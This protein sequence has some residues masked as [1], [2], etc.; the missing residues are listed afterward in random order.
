MSEDRPGTDIVLPLMA[1]V[2]LPVLLRFGFTQSADLWLLAPEL[3]IIAA[4]T[5]VLALGF[6]VGRGALALV[7][8]TGIVIAGIVSVLQLYGVSAWG[9]PAQGVAFG[10]V[11][12]DAFA[13][14]L[15]LVFLSVAGLVALASPTAV[16][17]RANQGE[18]YSL[19]LFATVGMMFVGGSR[20]LIMLFLGF[21]LSSFASYALAGYRK[22]DP[23]S[24]EAAM[25]FFING[26]LSSALILFGISLVYALTTTSVDTR[27][28]PG[29]VSFGNV[30]L[31]FSV[32]GLDPF[33][34][35]VIFA[36]MF[37]LAGFAFKVAAFPFHMWAPDVYD[38]SPTAVSAFLAAGSKKMGFAAL[39]KVFLVGLLAARANWDVLFGV[40]AIAT[41]TLGNVLAISQTNIKRMLAY[42]SIAQAGYILIAIPIAAASPDAV[43][44]YALAGGIFHIL[45]HAFMKGGA[46]IVVA[47][48]L[49]V[50]ISERIE[51]Y[52]G[53]SRRAP[54]MAFAMAVFLIS[55]A[56]IPPLAGFM[57]KFVLFSGAVNAS[58]QP[59]HG[60]LIILA[61]AGI[62]NSAVSLFYYAKV[63]R[64]MYVE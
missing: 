22:K 7:T 17:G 39:F 48:L 23:E 51:D 10:L 55:F 15:K 2:A 30:G 25:K 12:V 58:L 5:L 11:Q 35:M 56:G 61:I 34:L 31:L 50:G 27:V 52:K 3:L 36:V 20:D 40:V 32:G 13:L 26:A 19:L 9:M 54:L 24:V 41:M 28:I 38:G 57:S 16:P 62:L 60:W 45:T 64:I 6:A 21:E 8:L 37:L 33:S 53:L 47:A 1:A 44:Q 4:A 18:Y 59:E 63:V 49:A 29:D 14:V 43:G 42:S 46:F